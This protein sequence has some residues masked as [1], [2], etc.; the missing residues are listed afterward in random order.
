MEWLAEQLQPFF[1]WLLRTTVQASVLIGLILLLQV[2][3]SRRLG[4]RWHNSLWLLLLICM[5][6]PWKPQSPVSLFNLMPRSLRCAEGI[7]L[8]PELVRESA[9]SPMP[10]TQTSALAESKPAPAAPVAERTTEPVTAAPITRKGEISPPKSAPI[11][12]GKLLP[13]IWLAGALV[14]GLYVF[15]SNFKLWKIVRGQR[16]STDR[17]TLDLLEDCKAQMGI[18]TILGLVVTDKVKS[19]ALFGFVRPRLLLPKRMIEALNQEELRHVF[20][21]ELAHLKRFDIYLGWLMSLLQ[22]LHWFNPL[23]WLAF[24]RMRADRE[25]ACDALML[26]RT[27][28]GEPKA[29]GRTIVSL[30]ERFSRPQ[31]LPGMAGILETKSQL[32]RRLTMIARFKKKS[33]RWSPLAVILLVLLGCVAVPS[34]RHTKDPGI[35]T[36]KP[37]PVSAIGSRLAAG[38]SGSDVLET[39]P[40]IRELGIDHGSGGF[41]L[42]RDGNKLAYCRHMKSGRTSIVVRNLVSGE[43]TEVTDYEAGYAHFPVFSPDASQ[44]IC[45]LLQSS[46]CPLHIVSLETRKDRRLDHQGFA[47]DWSR[48]GRFVVTHSGEL[49]KQNTYGILSFKGD[50]VEK[51]DLAL[52]GGKQQY[53]DLRFSPDAKYVSYA[54]EG[55]LYLYP[56]NGGDEIQITRGSNGD[57]APIWSPGGKMLLFLSRRGFGPELDL[58]GV[59]VADGKVAGDVRVIRPDFA[60]DVEWSRLSDTG[61]LLYARSYT[62][63]I[64]SVT[65]DPQTGQPTGGPTRLASGSHPVWSPDG[66]RIAYIA[67]ESLH[68]MS[69][70]G[71]NDQEIIKVEF[72]P[73]S[74]YAWAA[75]NDTIYIPEFVEG[76]AVIYAI[77]TSTK[78]KRP[79]LLGGEG[80]ICGH[81]AC[82]PDG[83]KLAFLRRPPSSERYQV[84][85]VD[86]D[87]T[88]LRQLTCYEEGYVWY[89]TWSPDGKQIAF[90]YGPGGGIKTLRVVSVDDGKTRELFRGST[91]QDRFYQKS[92]SPDGSK[93]VWLSGDGIRVGQVSD[94]KYD[95]FKGSRGGEYGCQ[96]SADGTKMLFGVHRSGVH[97]SVEQLT[98]MD[99]F[100]PKA[101]E[102]Q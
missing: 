21:H 95:T 8:Q 15:A 90:E 82:S 65:I 52:P 57:K 51:A 46:A 12:I 31:R 64:Y 13:L 93:I 62:D 75:D 72:H 88:N 27:E 70:D 81:L 37:K 97:R 79:V 55:N 22:V 60:D 92:S 34:A 4:V 18:R 36:A 32:K 61:R 35:S 85:T 74:T 3:L 50:A 101:H 42:S 44:I 91:P 39:G 24:Y 1:Q 38:P 29:Y 73:T 99:N 40:V 94:G 11:Q 77:S 87:G 56:I 102:K 89:P 71:T 69:A 26:A 86:T 53:S 28:G 98:I 80:D 17:N 30:I 16:P 7:Y 14:L 25:L 41:S 83:K 48:D 54:R 45:T 96:W 78:E 6:M 23:V 63:N 84:F 76:K 58:C 68:V 9:E 19:P 33:Y 2:S 47:T 67:E 43:E 49:Q 5:V 66:K 59:P 20:L 100:L 10:T